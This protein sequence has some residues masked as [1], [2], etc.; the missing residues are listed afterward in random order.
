MAS[1]KTLSLNQ[2]KTKTFKTVMLT[3]AAIFILAFLMSFDAIALPVAKALNMEV[4]E[5]QSAAASIIPL[6]AGAIIIYAGVTVMA[7]P[8]LGAALV[9]V[10]AITVFIAVK[11]LLADRLDD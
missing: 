11:P 7:I 6:V 3:L 4:D 10:G 2:K 5:V 8:V 9:L 1:K